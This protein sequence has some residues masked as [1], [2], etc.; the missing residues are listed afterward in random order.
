MNISKEQ[1]RGAR[2]LLNIS[3][4][5]LADNV[6][7]ERA[8]ISKFEN[9]AQKEMHTSNIEKIYN[10]FTNRDIVFLENHGV[11]FKPKHLIKELSGRDG[12]RAFMDDVY[13]TAVDGNTNFRIQ[14]AHPANW[15]KHL[16]VDWY[17]K[18]AERMKEFADKISFKITCCEGNHNHIAGGFAEYRWVKQEFFNEQSI[19][20]YGDNVAFLNFNDEEIKIIVINSDEITQALT[21][22]FDFFWK[23]N[24]ITPNDN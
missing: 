16:G 8:S 3:Q 6:G 10:F 13:Q 17:E 7:I 23:H 18:H 14:N 24:T 11:A 9:G 22:T 5:E 19:Y 12:F 21:D 2:A 15:L 20:I 4:A 1:I